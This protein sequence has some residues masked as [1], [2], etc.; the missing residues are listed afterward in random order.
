[1]QPFFGHILLGIDASASAA[2]ARDYTASLAL[3]QEAA[4]TIVYPFA[5]ASADGEPI[6]SAARSFA[7]DAA[8]RLRE[9]GVA[10][11][12]TEVVWEPMANAIVEKAHQLQT[13]LIILGM[14][15]AREH[16]GK[17]D[18]LPVSLSVMQQAVCPVLVVR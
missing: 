6:D 8:E 4:V 13:D 14:H 7:V 3:N 9:F 16:H 10:Q 17:G 12:H 11:V 1:M 2:R 15:A 18:A 5:D